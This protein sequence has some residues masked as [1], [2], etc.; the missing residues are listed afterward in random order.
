L[1]LFDNK[2]KQILIYK[3]FTMK[4]GI[5]TF[6]NFRLDLDGKSLFNNGNPIKLNDKSFRLLS[7]LVSNH[8]TLIP[9]K[10]L[11]QKVW[12]ENFLNRP[13]LLVN[14]TNLRKILG[15]RPNG[16]E[17][18]VNKNRK[19]YVFS[20]DNVTQ[21][22][23]IEVVEEPKADNKVRRYNHF[24]GR[25]SEISF[26][27]N[28]YQNLL[29]KQGNTVLVKGEAGIGKTT[30]IRNFIQDNTKVKTIF[31][32]FYH[33]SI[34]KTSAFEICFKVI[35]EALNENQPDYSYQILAKKI[36]DKFQIKLPE[37]ENED[38]FNNFHTNKDN[39]RKI[40]EII[41]QIFKKLS[42][43]EPLLIIFDD[44][45]FAAAP[46]FEILERLLGLTKENPILLILLARETNDTGSSLDYKNWMISHYTVNRLTELS[47]RYLE[48]KD[49]RSL[50]KQ[51]F[52]GEDVAKEIPTEDFSLLMNIVHGNPYFLVEMIRWLLK[53]R[54]IYLTTE[55]GLKWRWQKLQK[56][57]VPQSLTEIVKAKLDELSS[58]TLEII[59]M[60]SVYGNT[61]S[62]WEVGRTFSVSLEKV[63]KAIEEAIGIGIVK[64]DLFDKDSFEF[65]HFL[66]RSIIND[67]LK[68]SKRIAAHR[69]IAEYSAGN[70]DVNS[71]I[72][73]LV[74]ICRHYEAAKMEQESF[75]WNIKAGNAL[76]RRSLW[77]DA[78]SH[79]DKACKMSAQVQTNNEELF[80]LFFNKIYCLRILEKVDESLEAF[81][82]LKK[83]AENIDNEIY[84]ADTDFLFGQMILPLSR[85]DEAQES[86][87][88]ALKIYR[89]HKI[90]EKTDIAFYY[91]IVLMVRQGRYREVI[92]IKDEISS[93]SEN[94][95][96]ILLLI[97]NQVANSFMFL[98]DTDSAK[99]IFESIFQQVKNSGDLRLQTNIFNNLS[100]VYFYEG[101]YEKAIKMAKEARLNAEQAEMGIAV[102]ESDYLICRAKVAQGFYEEALKV[103]YEVREK[104]EELKVSHLEAEAIC[105]MGQCCIETG[106][107]VQARRHLQTSLKMIKKIGDKDDESSILIQF[108]RLAFA[109]KEF[110][111]MYEYANESLK[112]AQEINN[113][114]CIGLALTELALAL[115]E[116]KQH[117][118]ALQTS[119]DAVKLLGNTNIA[120][121]WRAF[122][123]Q[124][125][126]ILI[127]QKYKSRQEKNSFETAE[128]YLFKAV[129]ILDDI[130][131]ESSSEEDSIRYSHIS[132]IF[133]EPAKELVKLMEISGKIKQ[134]R[135]TANDWMLNS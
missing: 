96:E 59:E 64:N 134:S 75:N 53:E 16:E 111:K 10:V 101:K 135:I 60:I 41:R 97:K 116:Q 110:K 37:I 36:F 22:Q 108:A 95:S 1:S 105:L 67:N 78:F 129:E 42:E 63:E 54:K 122:Y 4:K 23:Q 79:F 65:S 89:K 115:A 68:L 19:G 109:Q 69:K 47:I 73:T 128:K 61:F 5:I 131:A 103:L 6:D 74:K 77:K 102:Y 62:V 39:Y 132:R 119:A 93:E 123:T 56:V 33:Y 49:C 130:R 26:L 120:E 83:L 46:D 76:M 81:P 106:E 55:S 70:Q 90:S 117:Q 51:I 85:Y 71:N 18:I 24:V 44:I 84:S 27:E 8:S 126:V 31:V 7:F 40:I 66:Q 72:E 20:A 45:H 38:S 12:E 25:E 2:Q 11:F 57:T 112:A 88:K 32:G 91:K 125:K 9:T 98:N 86:F 17:Y 30:L 124:S 82:K 133:S 50:I 35:W 99:T 48:E 87:N 94:T 107:F 92:K 127:N 121:R 14:I 104:A 52:D 113:P 3:V 100:R 43:S 58:E 13:V 34:D 114:R 29:N 15:K 21:S 118:A 80:K 28:E